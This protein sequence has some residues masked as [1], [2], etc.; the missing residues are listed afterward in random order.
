[1]TSFSS[2]FT[3]SLL[4]YLAGS[5]AD[6]ATVHFYAIPHQTETFTYATFLKL[7]FHLLYL[8]WV[9]IVWVHLDL[10]VSAPT[11]QYG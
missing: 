11:A 9:E 10:L 3:F 2:T 1:M 8:G 4:H 5:M 7:G 6:C